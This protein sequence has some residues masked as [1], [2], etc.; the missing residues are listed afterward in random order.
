MNHAMAPIEAI[1]RVLQP[2]RDEVFELR[3]YAEQAEFLE[4]MAE[5]CRCCGH[6]YVRPCDACCAGGVCDAFDCTCEDEDRSP[7]SDE[8]AEVD[9]P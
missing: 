1:E 7:D 8:P 5:K 6:C 3:A 2:V 9:G 4:A